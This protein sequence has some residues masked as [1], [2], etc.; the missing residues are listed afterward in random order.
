MAWS[1]GRRRSGRVTPFDR[2]I[3]VGRLV[4]IRVS[5]RQGNPFPFPPRDGGAN[6]IAASIRPAAPPPG[7]LESQ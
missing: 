1:M 4:C 3:A 7:F 2:A 5:N 6:T